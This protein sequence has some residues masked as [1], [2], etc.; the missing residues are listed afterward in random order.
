MAARAIARSWRSSHEQLWQW[1]HTYVHM[2]A[3][4]YIYITYVYI[5]YNISHICIYVYIF[6]I[7]MNDPMI[8]HSL[9][10]I[11]VY[12]IV[13]I[14]SCQFVVNRGSWWIMINHGYGPWLL[15]ET[16]DHH[17]FW[18]LNIKHVFEATNLWG[19][20]GVLMLIYALI[21]EWLGDFNE[22]H[23]H[24]MDLIFG[25]LDPGRNL[26]SLTGAMADTIYWERSHE[27]YKPCQ[28]YQWHPIF[29]YIFP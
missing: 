26:N 28:L 20:H 24:I 9:W 4:M 2:Y 17:P 10:L 6:W 1:I 21:W 7:N 5:Y 25:N 3:Y 29:G 8:H 13:V 15:T 19:L 22:N 18:W 27:V 12:V 16:R 11:R 23:Q 14:D